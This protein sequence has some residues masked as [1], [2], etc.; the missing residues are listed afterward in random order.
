MKKINL[1][2]QK[3]KNILITGGNRGIGKGLLLNLCQN[4]NVFSVRDEAKV[5]Y[6]K[7]FT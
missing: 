5:K 7:K 4:H 3:M 6:N 1:N 2:N